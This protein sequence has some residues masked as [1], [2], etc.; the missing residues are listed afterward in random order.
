MV[1]RRMQLRRRETRPFANWQ[2]LPARSSWKKFGIPPGKKCEHYP[3][4]SKPILDGIILIAMVCLRFYAEKGCGT[5]LAACRDKLYFRF[6]FY[7]ERYVPGLG[8]AY[9]PIPEL[10]FI[11]CKRQMV[12]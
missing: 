9:R 1:R 11:F 5:K 8:D 3:L 6:Y 4:N 12:R 10:L 2:P 7:L